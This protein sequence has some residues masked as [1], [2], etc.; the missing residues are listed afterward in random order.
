MP[1]IPFSLTYTNHLPRA[2]PRNH[3]SCPAGWFPPREGP[4][5]GSPPWSVVGEAPTTLFTKLLLASATASPG[6]RRQPPRGQCPGSLVMLFTDEVE[7]LVLDGFPIQEI[8][9]VDA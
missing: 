5:E 8:S 7:A 6:E 2:A 3:R 1:V 4:C 9:E